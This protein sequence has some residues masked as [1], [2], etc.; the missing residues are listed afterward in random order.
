VRTSRWLAWFAVAVVVGHHVGTIFG[1]LGGAGRGTEW[2][3]WLDL[4][5]PY[6]VLGTAAGALLAAAATRRT[7]LVAALGAVV[8]VQ[9][10][11]IH[12]AANSVGN[13]R[14]DGQPVHLWDEVMGHYLWYGGL[15]AVVAALALAV[16]E[17]RGGAR[18]PL[19]ALFGL[20]MATNGIEGG[21]ALL[22]LAVAVAFVLW[23]VRRRSA[24]L[25]AAWAV[26]T[27][28]LAG[29]GLYWGVTDGRFF[30]QFSQL[31]WI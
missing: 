20:T 13:A 27:V 11:G 3:D 15:Y 19:A 23:A 24:V 7:W 4:L 22:T 12:L 14:G 2:A 30:P 29:W 31:G 16:P 1:P 6:A 25:T 17:P 10:H 5:T 21:T 26:A 28:L 9:G 18:W 8:Y